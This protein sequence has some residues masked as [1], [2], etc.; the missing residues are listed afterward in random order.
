MNDDRDLIDVLKFELNF[1]EKG[2]YGRSPR[3]PWRP[4]LVFE[5]SPTCMNYDRKEAP[6]PCNACVLM[7]LAP[8]ESRSEPVPCRNIPL[9]MAGETLDSLYR[10]GDQYEIEEAVRSWLR[11]TIT[12]LEEERK[13]ACSGIRA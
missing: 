13:T 5:D 2:G 1:L 10:Y 12:Q 8:R 11:T 9:N 6:A 3:Q 4:Q 7:D